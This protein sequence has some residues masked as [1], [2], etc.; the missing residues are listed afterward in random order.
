MSSNNAGHLIIIIRSVS[1]HITKLDTVQFSSPT[2][3]QNNE[4][5]PCPT[6]PLTISLHF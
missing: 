4:T 1:P 2:Y 3:F 5:L 6:E